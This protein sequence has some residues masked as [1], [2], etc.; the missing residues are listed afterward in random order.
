MK[1]VIETLTRGA[2]CARF[3]RIFYTSEAF[4]QEITS[5][6]HLKERV[7]RE[8]VQLP[9]GKEHSRLY[10]VPRVDLPAIIEKVAAG[11]AV[12]YEETS[13]FDP[14][15][16][17]AN[18]AFHTTANDLLRLSAV[19]QWFDEPAGVHMHIELD[20]HVKL[21]GVAGLVERFVIGETRKRYEAVERVMQKCVDDGHGLDLAHAA[22]IS[23]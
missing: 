5:A 11:Y 12:A 7:V 8:H 14:A 3:R 13:L 21:F 18:L 4:N 6:A 10:I 23:G 17:T 9:D 22:A 20:V 2:D 15:T 16:R 19:T 1:A